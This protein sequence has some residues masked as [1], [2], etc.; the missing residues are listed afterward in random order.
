M[1]QEINE[2][3][4]ITHTFIDGELNILISDGSDKIYFLD[5]NWKLKRILKIKSKNGIPIFYLN[6]L[7]MIHGKLLANV[8][9]SEKIVVIDLENGIAIK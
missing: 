1:P 3:W 9:L 2:G 6:E 5:V 4:G 8:Y 7:E